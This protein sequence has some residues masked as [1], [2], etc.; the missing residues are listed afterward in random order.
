MTDAHSALLRDRDIHEAA[1]RSEFSPEAWLAELRIGTM[2]AVDLD[3]L[4]REDDLGGALFR[5]IED[6]R[7]DVDGHE[8]LREVLR[9]LK[10]KLPPRVVADYQTRLDDR[11]FIAAAL[12]GAERVLLAEM[13]G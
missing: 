8:G 2:P 12:D 6:L 11:D 1:I 3:L 9:P 4:R 10:D 13:Y 7:S 5:S